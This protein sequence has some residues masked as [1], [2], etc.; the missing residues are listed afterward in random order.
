MR[1]GESPTQSVDSSPLLVE[2]IMSDTVRFIKAKLRK[3]QIRL[4]AS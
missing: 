3:Q 1:A 2:G 4:S